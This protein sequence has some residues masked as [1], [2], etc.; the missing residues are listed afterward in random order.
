VAVV[1]ATATAEHLPQHQT[2]HR[3][4]HQAGEYK[5]CVGYEVLVLLQIQPVYANMLLQWCSST[6]L[7]LLLSAA[8]ASVAVA[9]AK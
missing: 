9:A 5:M 3:I 8:A 2:H 4:G 6:A 7:P 1:A